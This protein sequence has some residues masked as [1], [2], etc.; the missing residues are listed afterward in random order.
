MEIQFN[1]FCA[2]E[3]PI[4]CNQSHWSKVNNYGTMTNV[5]SCGNGDIVKITPVSRFQSEHRESRMHPALPMLFQP[6]VSNALGIG[7]TDIVH[8]RQLVDN[9]FH[10]HSHLCWNEISS[11][12]NNSMLYQIPILRQWLC[13]TRIGDRKKERT[14]NHIEKEGSFPTSGA[15]MTPLVELECKYTPHRI[16]GGS[17]KCAV[18]FVSSPGLPS[19]DAHLN[20]HQDPKCFSIYQIGSEKADVKTVFNC[21]PGRDVIFVESLE[22]KTIFLDQD[23]VHLEVLA[24]PEEHT[25]VAGPKTRI[26]RKGSAYDEKLYIHRVFLLRSREFLFLASR[27]EDSRQLVLYGGDLE[28]LTISSECLIDGKK[29]KFWFSEGE[30]ILSV[31]ELP[32]M[33]TSTNKCNIAIA[34]S[35]RILIVGCEISLNILAECQQPSLWSGLVPLGSYCVSFISHEG[36]RSQVKYLSCL[37]GDD[38]THVGTITNL[39]V[40]NSCLANVLVGLRPDR[41]VYNSIF[42]GCDNHESISLKIPLTK[43]VFLLEP[44][45]ASVLCEPNSEVKEKS[46]VSLLER[47]GVKRGSNPHNENEGIG[48]KG[49]GL[50]SLVFQM[51]NKHGHENLIT[52]ISDKRNDLMP[53][54]PICDKKHNREKQLGTKQLGT[55]IQSQNTTNDNIYNIVS[56]YCNRTLHPSATGNAIRALNLLGNT[57]SRNDSV[58][59]FLAAQKDGSQ[60]QTN[61]RIV[62]EPKKNITEATFDDRKHFWHRGPFNKKEELLL[63]NSIE[64]WVG[65]CR[66]SILGKEGAELAAESGQVTLQSILAQAEKGI[67]KDEND[68]VESSQCS[69]FEAWV[70][71]V[72]QGQTDEEKLT[73]YLRFFEGSDEDSEWRNNCL[74][75]LSSFQNKPKLI[76]SENFGIEATTSNVDEGES[77]TVRLL[78]DLVFNQDIQD[79]DICGLFVEVKRGSSLDIGMF[80]TGINTSRQRKTL[81]FWYFLPK[82]SKEIILARRSVC[83]Q[84]GEDIESLC[85]KAEKESILWE[86]VVLPTGRLEFRCCGG[87]KMDT[88]NFK[89]TQQNQHGEQNVD[90]DTD[91]EPVDAGL[92]SLPREDGYG[93]WNHVCLSFSSKD[94]SMNEC[95]VA[96]S[97]KGIEINSSIFEMQLP[98]P[99]LE[100]G[101]TLEIDDCLSI[102]ALMFGIGATAGF[103]LTEL[104]VW[105]YQ[106]PL[107]DIKSMMYEYL[108]VAKIKKK[109]FKLAIRGKEKQKKAGVLAP[110]KPKRLDGPESDRTRSRRL[111]VQNTA[112][113]T[114]A[115]DT[116]ESFANFDVSFNDASSGPTLNDG[117][118][119]R[120][121]S[122]PIPQDS[123]KLMDESNAQTIDTCM[124][125]TDEVPYKIIESCLLSE[126]VRKSA[127]AAIIR[128]APATKHFGGNRGGLVGN[129]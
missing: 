35:S 104:R 99:G 96:I 17:S 9:F 112:G 127:A 36:G 1:V 33:E 67:S 19:P 83:F 85:C 100:Q 41:V 34:T 65:K 28:M 66:P 122:N 16:V 78:H 31:V 32:P 74:S 87:G 22:T 63:L 119:V 46:L 5:V 77:G 10:V 125:D 82:C 107:A 71:N 40:N 61:N 2:D 18:L 43:P 129:Q 118:L 88:A 97:M 91:D 26:F 37:N 94:L 103:R 80:H 101:E 110:E 27:K 109:K 39:P 51:L 49:I 86:L 76:E 8:S 106:R 15:Q 54:I 64:E 44:L 45:I 56:Q 89:S 12:E 57:N 92:V 59:T 58:S 115:F 79:D 81:E 72:G 113:T 95:N 84:N 102:S 4:T 105:A 48:T 30:R 117:R 42:T 3:L 53:W 108:D 93:G 14:K 123:V 47:F 69:S 20:N 62:T 52:K 21:H 75:D 29:S 111:E 121:S 13:L 6:V 128:G 90:S 11:T 25:S 24:F 55:N 124:K 73:L 70:D 116:Q 7:S 60:H 38:R 68:D 50:T 98:S 114:V 126:D 120:E 23:G